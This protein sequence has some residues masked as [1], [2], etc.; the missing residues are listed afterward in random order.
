MTTTELTK[1]T[2]RYRVMTKQVQNVL[3]IEYILK[4]NYIYSFWLIHRQTISRLLVHPSTHSVVRQCWRLS[5][6]R[7]K[8]RV[9]ILRLISQKR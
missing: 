6:I 1:E 2:Y 9:I 7:N 8:I 3:T 4:E 5:F